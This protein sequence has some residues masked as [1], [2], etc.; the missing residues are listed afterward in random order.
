VAGN[1]AD[2]VI[3]VDLS[4]QCFV[5]IDHRDFDILAGEIARDRCPDLSGPAYDDFHRS[6]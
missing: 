2:L 3:L 6:L 4:H 1:A 5:N